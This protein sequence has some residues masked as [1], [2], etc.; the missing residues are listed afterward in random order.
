M[1]KGIFFDLGWTIFRPV[2]DN[3]FINQKMLEF[4]SMQIIDSLPSEK[5]KTAFNKALKY[6]DDNHLLFS[7]DEEVEQFAG[8]YKIIAAELPELLKGM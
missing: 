6:L 2:N 8:F 1:I 4:T 3:W 7:E 5:R